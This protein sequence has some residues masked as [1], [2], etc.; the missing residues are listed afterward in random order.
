M[1][2]T[3]GQLRAFYDGELSE[4]ELTHMQAHFDM[5]PP[6]RQLAESLHVRAGHVQAVLAALDPA[7][8]ES[9][10]LVRDARSHFEAY[11][12]TKEKIPMFQKLFAPRFRLAWAILAIAVVLTATLGL[13]PVRAIANDFLGLFRV[14]QVSAVPFDP[15][16]LPE[17]FNMDQTRITE[18]VAENLKIE[19]LGQ[20]QE[21]VTSAEASSLAGI[22]VRLPTSP[23]LSTG[24]PKLSVEPGTRLEFKVDLPRVQAI[25]S[26]A[27][28]GD[29]QLPKEL[30]GTTVKA[31]LPMIVTA[32]YGEYMKPGPATGQDPDAGSWCVDC[33]VLVQLASP[34][35]ETPEGVDLAA[36]GKAYLRLTGMTDAEAESF[37]QT[38]DWSTTLVI[39]VPSF[40]AHETVSVD[41][42]NGMLIQQNADYATQYML[43]WAKD[44]I[45]YALSGYGNRQTALEIANSLK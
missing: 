25:V 12:S 39:P 15:L 2:P 4:T 22:P 33:T 1:H 43:I 3:E 14:Q 13:P 18:L 35:V 31:E 34:T 20:A 8:E 28:F 44:G 16:N 36:I 11:S 10:A 38:V 17:N 6:C 23:A 32:M 19:T 9:A 27:G 40:T 37:S 45:V 26:D 7:P 21:G 24:T 30:D 42:V 5:C 41:G 29:I